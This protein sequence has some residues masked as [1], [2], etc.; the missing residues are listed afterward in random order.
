MSYSNLTLSLRSLLLALVLVCFSIGM[1]G[2]TKS[3]LNASGTTLV[4]AADKTSYILVGNEITL[5]FSY[6]NAI[7]DISKIE[8]I[9]FYMDGKEYG[10]AIQYTAS[11]IKDGEC[12]V[13]ISEQSVKF[14]LEKA[15]SHEFKVVLN[16]NDSK[17]EKQTRDLSEVKK[18]VSFDIPSADA[19]GPDKKY[20]YQKAENLEWT[21]NSKGGYGNGWKYDWTIN[22]ENIT[23]KTISIPFDKAGS[24]N[25]SLAAQNIAPDNKTVWFKYND[26][27]DNIIVY[28]EAKSSIGSQPRESVIKNIRD[29]T[30]ELTWG[31]KT[32]G[33]YEK[34]WKYTW[35]IDGKE[36]S[37]GA[38]MKSALG[39]GKHN[40]SVVVENLGPQNEKW[41][42]K[43]IVF[44]TIYV[45]APVTI[46]STPQLT[47][48]TVYYYKKTGN[49]K[50]TVSHVGGNEDE[51]SWSY[52]WTDNGSVV[53]TSASLE[54][55]Y[56]VKE[57]ETHK[58]VC[59]VTNKDAKGGV[60]DEQTKSV[61]VVI[62]PEASIS[63]T[64]APDEHY[65]YISSGQLKWKATGVGG[66]DS[67]WKY[68]W[69]IKIGGKEES[70]T[71]ELSKTFTEGVY[72][73][74]LSVTNSDPTGKVLYALNSYSYT[75][76]V[77]KAVE[78]SISE[79][80]VRYYLETKAN[81]LKYEAKVSGGNENGWTYSWSSSYSNGDYSK[82]S[83]E[84]T[85]NPSFL[86]RGDYFVYLECTN[87]D[88]NGKIIYNKLLKSSRVSV[89]KEPE[90]VITTPEKEEF[91]YSTG[92]L[93]WSVDAKYGYDGNNAWTYSWKVDDAPVS[94]NKNAFTQ[95]WEY[96]GDEETPMP[97]TITVNVKNT[98]ADGQV[99]YN[100]TH[101]FGIT[102]Q[103]VGFIV[104]GPKTNSYYYKQANNLAWKIDPKGLFKDG[105]KYSW[106]IEGGSQESTETSFST[107]FTEVGQYKV[108][109]SASNYGDDA[110]GQL[111][112][113]DERTF[114]VTVYPEATAA[115]NK[116]PKAVYCGAV[117]EIWSVNSTGGNDQGWEYK[118]EVTKNSNVEA[119]GNKYEFNYQCA[120]PT[121]KET[122]T[123]TLDVS[124]YSPDRSVTPD[125]WYSLGTKTYNFTV[126]PTPTAS[127]R[128]N[129]KKETEIVGYYGNSYNLDVVCNGG[130]DGN[131]AWSYKWTKGS[132]SVSSTNKYT[133]TMSEKSVDNY[134]ETINVNVVNTYTP[135]GD[136]WL[137]YS[138]EYHI[139]AYSRGN[140]SA[141]SSNVNNINVYEGEY[142][143]LSSDVTG[144]YPGGWSYVWT[145]NG[146]I[147]DGASTPNYSFVAAPNGDGNSIEHTYV[148]KAVN[149]IGEEIGG[150]YTKEYKLVI[151]KKCDFSNV[152][153]FN[154]ATQNRT[155]ISEIREGNLL[156]VSQNQVSGG[157]RPNESEYWDYTWM[158]GSQT[159]DSY[160][161]SIV[162]PT[163]TGKSMNS[164][165]VTYSVSIN[166]YGP[167]KNMWDSSDNIQKTI[168]VYHRPPTPT[169]LVK[170]GNGTS[171]ALIASTE[172]ISDTELNQFKY[173]LVFG[174]D[175]DGSSKVLQ[176]VIQA[177]GTTRFDKFTPE[178][179]SSTN[180]KFWVYA[181]WH[182]PDNVTITSG[183]R[184]LSGDLDDS[185][186]GSSYT[187]R[188]R[189]G[190]ETTSISE[191]TNNSTLV[192]D[193]NHFEVS[194]SSAAEPIVSIYSLSGTV[195]KQ[196]HYGRG[197]HF[198]ESIDMSG[199]SN[200]IYIVEVI[201]G[202][203]RESVKVNI[204]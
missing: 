127:I 63:V 83:E 162:I 60:L 124:N 33:G 163:T 180:N 182:Y 123:V 73:V 53:S 4:T 80:S 35:K 169:K 141:I 203:N 122:K 111:L 2:Q 21:V 192:V 193:A 70:N 10:D 149:Q 41:Y 185:F 168:T 68:S 47:D 150:I 92:D 133:Y 177:T 77:Y 20:Y 97:K 12:T 164:Y 101:S 161:S 128:V 18:I 81:N 175:R 197:L 84:K 131:N 139:K 179:L 38:E 9:R 34:G 199:L 11:E 65:F 173:Y 107:S 186:D 120:N 16:C 17:N 106:S 19:K 45:Y 3:E 98:S 78:I 171:G 157:Y 132:S 75:L 103:P 46:T 36:V 181:E 105:W 52:K 172:G 143:K 202:N 200:G 104:D 176:P 27:K 167:N 59:T 112:H 96:E 67:G 191:V 116:T 158:K 57:T 28:G 30:S 130:Y 55:S 6:A 148:L 195:V 86:N 24:Y 50:W 155:N 13:T 42:S 91:Y 126:Y 100:K 49:L 89:Y 204:K 144:G 66:N 54:R 61:T 64:D 23:G 88:P 22:N 58:I 62:Y 152:V 136:E 189:S 184:Y 72:Y 76:T 119:T 114:T 159:L 166:N 32:E 14:K 190:N 138:E 194:L 135:Y 165:D 31:V 5:S 29:K 145:D 117:N 109:L 90:V 26:F 8:S 25:I 40:V 1:N 140:I 69:K 137:N 187:G 102:I 146:K 129:G 198:N 56:D 115:P 108:N 93:T 147:I 174:Y 51:S 156:S 95:S 48:G 201:A 160:D 118:W 39:V 188:T 196:Q 7:Q 87:R 153:P 142:I 113:K 125:P 170:K 121:S 85:Y 178:E 74:T 134:S 71:S 15:E 79:P 37:G 43:E 154:D 44:D 94:D 82:T 151:W 99:W 110:E 183:K